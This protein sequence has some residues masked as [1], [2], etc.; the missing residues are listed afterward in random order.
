MLITNKS[1]T[2]GIR[3]VEKQL[4]S[5][6]ATNNTVF[7]V[8]KNFKPNSLMIFVNGQKME[9]KTSPNDATEYDETNSNTKTFGGSLQDNDV[10]EFFIF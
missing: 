8:S 10:I 3:S 6:G 2:S 4:G 7:T 9:L 5:N 1:F